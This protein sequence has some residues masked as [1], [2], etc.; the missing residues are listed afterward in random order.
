MKLTKQILCLVLALMMMLAVVACGGEPANTTATTANG[1][2]NADP[3]ATTGTTVPDGGNDTTGTT[4]NVG[5]EIKDMQGK[6]FIL[7]SLVQSA[8]A[9]SFEADRDGTVVNN[10]VFQRNDDLETRLNCKFTVEETVGDTN[11]DALYDEMKL[12]S[13]LPSYNIITTATYRMV[14]L[15]VEGMLHDLA[16]Q[17]YIDLEQDYYDD[18]Y[19]Y[20]LNTAGR[21]YLATGKFTISW[22]RYQF[23]CLFNRNLFKELSL[24][25]PYDT[26]LAQQWTTAEMMKYSSRM[27]KDLNGN[28]EVDQPDQFGLYMYVGGGSSQTDGWMGAFGLRLV[29][30]TEDGYFKMMEIDKSTWGAA[31]EELLE[32][33]E[34]NGSWC[35]NQIGNVGVEN[36]FIAGEAGMIVYRMYFVESAEMMKLGRTREGYGIVPL[37]KAN[38]DQEDY[39]SYVQDQV[40]T[41][42][43]PNTMI[44][45]DLDDTALFYETF[46]Y[47][48]YKT[49]MPA[50]Y[51]RALTKRYVIDERSKAMIE[52]IDSN[53]Y[54][55]PVNVYYSSYFPLTT[56]SLRGVYD[57]SKT[58][59]AIL[60]SQYG[61]AF[62]TKTEALNTAL[63]E[64]D[65]RLKDQ[66]M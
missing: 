32:L 45:Q 66:G 22:Y 14:R 28:G 60:E 12:L 34:G 50:Y 6:E 49:V 27:W 18:S 29:E 43:I 20:V 47:E 1:G 55:D 19:N 40:L 44:G 7:R 2:Q 61:E 8:N 41:F 30:K 56:G 51:E 59:T 37:P 65:Q 63:K 21:Q 36:K 64:L 48:S 54:V 3:N 10:A 53:I 26:V 23:V 4:S 38:T 5:P 33:I 24:E 11:T 35:N 52:I 13:N 58:I 62:E 46:A 9:K 17:N 42:G 25:Y 39:Y 16:S 57:G 15:A 31:I